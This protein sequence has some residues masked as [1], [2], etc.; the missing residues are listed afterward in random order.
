MKV[1][2]LK[3]IRKRFSILYNPE[4]IVYCGE[5]LNAKYMIVD[6]KNEYWVSIAITKEEAIENLMRRIRDI[7]K[8]DIVNTNIKIWYNK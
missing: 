2:L 3:K 5:Q 1:K 8:S 4:G 7:Y 6:S